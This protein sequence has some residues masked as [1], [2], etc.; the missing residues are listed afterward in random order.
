MPDTPQMLTCNVCN[1]PCRNSNLLTLHMLNNHIDDINSIMPTRPPSFSFVASHSRGVVMGTSELPRLP[2][3]ARTQHTESL[4]GFRLD[5][6][7]LTSSGGSAVVTRISHDTSPITTTMISQASGT[8][9]DL[10][11]GDLVR[12]PGN[13]CPICLDSLDKGET[14]LTPCCNTQFHSECLRTLSISVVGEVFPCPNC[15]KILTRKWAHSV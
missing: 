3:V 11:P 12:D 8:V 9:A 4:S 1:M 6:S 5:I 10:D 15:R 14:S 7:T 13:E 2:G